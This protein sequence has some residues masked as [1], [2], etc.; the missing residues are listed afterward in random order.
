[1]VDKIISNGELMD[2]IRDQF[3]EPL[4]TNLSIKHADKNGIYK[5]VLKSPTSLKDFLNK[6]ERISK[7]SRYIQIIDNNKTYDF[8]ANLNDFITNLTPLL[9]DIFRVYLISNIRSRLDSAT[10]GKASRVFIKPL[11][12]ITVSTRIDSKDSDNPNGIYIPNSNLVK[13]YVP[14]ILSKAERGGVNVN[15][16]KLYR[17]LYHELQHYIQHLS[18]KLNGGNEILKDTPDKDYVERPIEIEARIVAGFRSGPNIP[19][20]IME[21]IKQDKDLLRLMRE[22]KDDYDK[23]VDTFVKYKWKQLY[24]KVDMEFSSLVVREKDPDANKKVIQDSLKKEMHNHKLL[25]KP[26]LDRLLL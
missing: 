23:L 26:M 21:L 15:T 19:K 13:A 1:M 14:G 5:T 18:S 17:I 9:S 22:M 20:R 11:N 3:N 25:I 6:L 7:E 24:S 4:I 12:I 10:G 16:Y 8:K 2:I